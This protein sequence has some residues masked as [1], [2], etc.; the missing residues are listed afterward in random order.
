MVTS[1][2]LSFTSLWYRFRNA[3]LRAVLRLKEAPSDP[4]QVLVGAGVHAYPVADV[5]EERDLHGDAG[6]QGGRLVSARGGVALEA[7]VGLRDLEVNVRR[8][9][10]AYYFA[11]GRQ[12]V[13]GA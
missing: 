12:Y 10:D 8:R 7:R 6:L 5:D 1:R 11:V 3:C 9:L 2:G 13:H 4:R